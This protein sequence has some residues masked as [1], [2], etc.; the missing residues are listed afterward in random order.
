MPAHTKNDIS[1][2]R[3]GRLKVIR[4]IPD[5]SAYAKFLCVC[6]C[7]AQKI[8]HSQALIRHRTLSCGCY[9]REMTKKRGTIH[10]QGGS[11]RSGAYSSWANMMDRCEWGG[12]QRM[13]ARYGAKGIR[14]CEEWHEFQNF[15][16]DMGERPDGTSI[17]RIDGSL[18]YSKENCRWATRREQNLNTSRII[19]VLFEGSAITVHELCEKLCLSKPA[20]RARASR[21]G[22]DY[23]K[24]LQSIGVECSYLENT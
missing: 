12:N 13:Y 21:R 19:R 18:G 7:G 10:G 20:V 3:Y 6:D 17:D 9:G 8:V 24:A 23:V 1:G 4:F 5:D 2:N 14:V 11:D 15:F 22:N 16:N